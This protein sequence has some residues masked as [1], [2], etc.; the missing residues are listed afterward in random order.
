VAWSDRPVF[1]TRTGICLQRQN[2]VCVW[3][4]LLSESSNLTLWLRLCYYTRHG[5]IHNS[6]SMVR[7]LWTELRLAHT[8]LGEHLECLQITVS[9]CYTV[10]HKP[11]SPA[12]SIWCG[13]SG[14]DGRGCYSTGLRRQD[15]NRICFKIT[16]KGERDRKWKGFERG[17]VGNW[18]VESLQKVGHVAGVKG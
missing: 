10:K 11:Q 1:L 4:H 6:V 16:W 12:Y 8:Y 7:R 9:S 3:R 17:G 15:I 2:W 14:S 13:Y 5:L 18:R